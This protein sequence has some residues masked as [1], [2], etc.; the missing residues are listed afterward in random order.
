MD[1]INAMVYYD[2]DN[3]EWFRYVRWQRTYDYWSFHVIGFWNPDTDFKY[4]SSEDK[5]IFAGEGIQF[6]AVLNI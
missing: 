5:D 6:M 2:W 1:P 4:D 3:D